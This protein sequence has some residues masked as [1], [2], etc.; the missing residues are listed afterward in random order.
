MLFRSVRPFR[1]SSS[2]SIKLSFAA[3]AAAIIPKSDAPIAHKANKGFHRWPEFDPGTGTWRGFTSW[4]GDGLDLLQWV[5]GLEI[6][7]VVRW[8]PAGYR[9]HATSTPRASSA[10]RPSFSASSS[11]EFPETLAE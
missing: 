10:P 9:I 1:S 5:M 6:W 11:A 2:A 8:N 3:D 7:R 4:S